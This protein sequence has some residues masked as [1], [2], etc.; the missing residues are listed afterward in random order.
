MKNRSLGATRVSALFA[1]IAAL[2][3]MLLAS[4][5]AAQN[6]SQEEEYADASFI[7]SMSDSLEKRMDNETG[8]GYPSAEEAKKL[9]SI[10]LDALTAFRDKRFEDSKLQE[11]ALSYINLLEDMAEAAALLDVQSND[12]S[13]EK[14][15][16]ELSNE[17]AKQLM[18]FA[19]NHGLTVDEAHSGKFET[20]IK[21]GNQAAKEAAESEAVNA[22]VDTMVFEKSNDGYGFYTYT[23]IAEN[24]TEYDLNHVSLVLSL[25]D[26]D[27]VKANQAYAS[28]NEWLKGEKVRFEAVSDV[29]AAE[30]KVSMDGYSIA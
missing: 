28:T 14:Q 27:G 24:T 8:F 12:G 17:R 21:Q 18:N 4:G 20:L 7:E 25:Y 10:E 16:R 2:L 1:V 9:A 26:A 23:C 19:E 5:C 13:T 30:I 11:A 3:A 22:L 15:W 6:D 29:D